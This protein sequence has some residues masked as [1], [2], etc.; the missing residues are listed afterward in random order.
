MSQAI[1]TT[2]HDV[3]RKWIES[4]KGRPSIVKRTENTKQ[5]AGVLRIDFKAPDEALDPVGWDEFFAVFDEKELAF[6][7]QERTAAGR[8][9]RFNKFVSRESVQDQLQEDEDEEEDDADEET[10]EEEEEEEEDEDEDEED[11]EDEDEDDDDDE[12]S[13]P[14]GA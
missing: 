14:R 8:K 11:E 3:I 2:D 10:E 5:G 1:A 12:T 7:C 9:S 6:L 13:S 4:R